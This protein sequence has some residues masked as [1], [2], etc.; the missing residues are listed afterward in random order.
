MSPEYHIE[1]NI[2]EQVLYLLSSNKNRS[3]LIS[4]AKNGC[5]EM[6]NSGC[7]PRG[8]HVICEKMGNGC[9]PNTVFVGRKAT[10]ELYSLSLQKEFPKRDWI[11]TRILWLDGRQININQGGNLDSRKRYIYIH[12]SPDNT[13][14][15]KPSSSGCVRMKNHD[16]IELFDLVEVNTPVNIIER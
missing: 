12:G 5:G 15:G 14:M 10:G 4:T 11:L 6:M 3:Y 16:I 2:H 7:T 9:A 1:I 8:K 13:A